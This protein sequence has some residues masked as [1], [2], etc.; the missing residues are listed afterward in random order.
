[1]NKLSFFGW[2]N[3]SPLALNKHVY[4]RLKN[5]SYLYF[6]H[7][8]FYMYPNLKLMLRLAIRDGKSASF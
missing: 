1:M 8:Q 6:Q 7:C 4:G 5:A 3:G 2:T